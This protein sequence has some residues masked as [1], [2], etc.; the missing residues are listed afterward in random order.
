M[1]FSISVSPCESGG[2]SEH[3]NGLF[4]IKEHVYFQVWRSNCRE[5]HH[6][7]LVP[8][9]SH[10]C[11]IPSIFRAM[12]HSLKCFLSAHHY[13]RELSRSPRLPLC[14]FSHKSNRITTHCSVKD[15]DWRGRQEDRLKRG[16]RE[17]WK[18]RVQ[19][20][21]Q[22]AMSLHTQPDAPRSNRPVIFDALCQLLY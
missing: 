16:G 22:N 6:L 20:E 8:L 21:E 14:W 10:P 13:N 15:R 17:R 1:C 9:L 4:V 19:V 3:V 5:S 7:P 2:M 18:W 12:F 11:I